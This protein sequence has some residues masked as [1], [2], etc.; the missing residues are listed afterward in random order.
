MAHPNI[1]VLSPLPSLSDSP[2]S[3]TDDADRFFSGLPT[4]RVELNALGDYLDTLA[5]NID[6][7]AL[8]ADTARLAAESA[9]SSAEAASAV[10]S[11]SAGITVYDNSLSYSPPAAVMG[12]NGVVYRCVITTTVGDNPVVSTSGKW[13][14]AISIDSLE[15]VTAAGRAIAT[16]ANVSAQQS[17]IGVAPLLL[18]DNSGAITYNASGQVVTMSE[19]LSDGGTRASAYTYNGDG[20]VKTI[21]VS[22]SGGT[23]PVATRITAF[24]YANGQLTGWDVLEAMQA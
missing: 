16:A 19:P 23:V 18:A 2:E 15:G 1:S 13:A 17:A 9:K 14:K 22:K 7:D 24:N 21:T 10:S 20:T 8:A 11:A 6:S 12:S 4:Y 3:F 5:T